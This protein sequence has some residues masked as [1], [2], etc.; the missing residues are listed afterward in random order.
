MS[1]KFPMAINRVNESEIKVE[2]L[3]TD[4]SFWLQQQYYL[5]SFLYKSLP[6][7]K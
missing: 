5:K 3:I 1:H 6:A 7:R 2:G 4:L